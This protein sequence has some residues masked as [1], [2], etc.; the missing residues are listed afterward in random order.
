MTAPLPADARAWGVGA[1][2]VDS[3]VGSRELYAI[4]RADGRLCIG[5]ARALEP[6]A[7]VRVPAST[8]GPLRRPV[9]MERSHCSLLTQP[10]L[11]PG[12]ASRTHAGWQP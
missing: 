6:D 4:R 9:T 2:S 7:A 1:F 10:P 12:F 8:A 11:P 3:D 5:G